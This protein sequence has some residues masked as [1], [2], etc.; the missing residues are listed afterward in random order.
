MQV[1]GV[2]I[3]E[4]SVKES[5]KKPLWLAFINAGMIV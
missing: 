3:D 2:R 1:A 4:C 5:K